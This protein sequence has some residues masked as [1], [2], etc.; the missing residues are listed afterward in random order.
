MALGAE[1]QRRKARLAALAGKA[2]EPPGD[3]PPPPAP[4]QGL[5]AWW[6][7]GQAQTQHLQAV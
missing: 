7:A 2:R 3:P 1:A 6:G 5:S 4:A